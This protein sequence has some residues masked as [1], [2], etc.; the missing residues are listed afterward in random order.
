M[1]VT[2]STMHPLSPPMVPK[3]N[4]GVN[5]FY[6]KSTV[7]ATVNHFQYD[8][9][10]QWIYRV[11][12]PN[13]QYKTTYY[14]Q[15]GSPEGW[16]TTYN[17]TTFPQGN[18]FSYTIAI[19]GDFGLKNDVSLAYLKQAAVNNQFDIVFHIGDFAYDLDKENGQIGDQWLRAVQD[20]TATKP[21]MVLAGNHEVND[22]QNFTHY[23]NRFTVP[24]NNPYN[25]TQFYSFNLGPVH[26]TAL[27]S[28]YVCFAFLY[29]EQLAINQYNWIS[30]DLQQA[31]NNRAN[32]PWIIAA[33]H[34]PIYWPYPSSVSLDD[35]DIVENYTLWI[36]KDGNDKMPGLEKLYIDSEVDMLFAGHVHGYERNYPIANG[37]VYKDGPNPYHNAK[38]PIH[39][40]TGS[41]GNQEGQDTTDYNCPPSP[42]SAQRSL[43]Y[44]YTLLHV[45]NATHMHMEQIS[46]A[47]NG[48]VIDDIWII[49][50]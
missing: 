28:E 15:V 16:S 8:F 12:L 37:T 1:L 17:F 50:D 25:D 11:A 7:N 38:A 42:S 9:G 31:K 10:E 13:L 39:I 23:R 40:T 36:L 44:G 24:I 33:M 49:K 5:P 4:Y 35:G 48:K 47:D 14:Y 22:L 19:Y 26:Y 43:K 34:R 2:W 18:N 20:I 32:Q 6:L 45:Y 29:G 27:S 3:V 41:A 30:Q 21:Y 46:V